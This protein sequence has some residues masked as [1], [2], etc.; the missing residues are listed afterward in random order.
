MAA[1]S[2]KNKHERNKAN[3]EKGHRTNEMKRMS[4]NE[5]TTSENSSDDEISVGKLTN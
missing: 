5:G 1:D 3:I 4:Q 2:E